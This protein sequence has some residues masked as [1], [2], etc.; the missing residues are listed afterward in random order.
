[1]M[2]THAKL[3]QTARGTR[4]CDGCG[5]TKGLDKFGIH[6]R[7]GTPMRKCETCIADSRRQAGQT[8]SRNAAKAR[9]K[10]TAA[11]VRAIGK[12]AKKQE[13]A[14]VLWAKLDGYAMAVNDGGAL[15]GLLGDLKKVVTIRIDNDTKGA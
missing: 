11:D 15:A 13:A 4:R 8:K 6:P 3:A 1:M 2:T 7:W 10:K 5:R 9:E 14:A 12:K